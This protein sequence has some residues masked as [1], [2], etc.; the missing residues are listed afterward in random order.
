[1]DLTPNYNTPV[2]EEV[3]A[4][5]AERLASGR[6]IH[7]PEPSDEEDELDLGDENE[8][9]SGQSDIVKKGPGV[10]FKPGDVMTPVNPKSVR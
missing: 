10:H 3:I 8:A 5:R 1:M 4:R 7:T 9:P 6:H 2:M